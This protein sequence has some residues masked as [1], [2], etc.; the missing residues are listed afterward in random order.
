MNL[1]FP[2]FSALDFLIRK[3]KEWEIQKKFLSFL[4]LF[5]YILWYILETTDQVSGTIIF[6][7]LKN[8]MSFYSLNTNVIDD[9][10]I[11]TKTIIH[12][13]DCNDFMFEPPSFRAKWQKS[14]RPDF[15]FEQGI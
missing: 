12:Q 2:I 9:V 6:S 11:Q 3:I 10:C 8:P 1:N 14:F 7:V 13:K 4:T 15:N 5:F